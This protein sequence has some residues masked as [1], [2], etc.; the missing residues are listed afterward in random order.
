MPHEPLETVLARGDVIR[1][2]LDGVPYLTYP[3]LDTLPGIRA[4]TTLREPGW[5]GETPADFLVRVGPWLARALKVPDA[6]FAAGRQ[7]HEDTCVVIGAENEPPPGQWRRYEDTDA[8][9]T[10]RP[11]WHSPC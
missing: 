11:V 6:S 7:V 10:D 8:L 1:H 5:S 4:L 9:M 2:E 3:V